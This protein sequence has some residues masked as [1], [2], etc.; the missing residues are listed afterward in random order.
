MNPTEEFQIQLFDGRAYRTTATGT[1]HRSLSERFYQ[2]AGCGKPRRLVRTAKGWPLRPS[3]R[4][5]GVPKAAPVE[6]V[7]T[8]Y[9]DWARAAGL[10]CVTVYREDTHHAAGAAAARGLQ[11]RRVSRTDFLGEA[12]APEAIEEGSTMTTRYRATFTPQA[13][14]NDYAVCVD[15][16][17]ETE[18][19][20]TAYMAALPTD[21]VRERSMIPDTYCSDYVKGD[22]AAPEW[23]REWT[24]PFYVT[25]EEDA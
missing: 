15:P 3:Y 11:V 9:M 1:N 5:P 14:I 6:A 2:L 24:G 7:I 16:A 13:W 18:W 8:R 22:P 17:G 20:C 21:E 10:E 12:P 25:V 23:V 4:R 19:D